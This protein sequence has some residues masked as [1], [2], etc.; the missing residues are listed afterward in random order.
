MNQAMN[1]AYLMEVVDTLI[2]NA[3][4]FLR[5]N[6]IFVWIVHGDCHKHKS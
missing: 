1:R 4:E 3:F 2:L 5:L 6:A